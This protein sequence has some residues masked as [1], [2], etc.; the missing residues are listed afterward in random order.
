MA[1]RTTSTA[2]GSKSAA[3]GSPD[4]SVAGRSKRRE[5]RLSDTGSDGVPYYMTAVDRLTNFSYLVHTPSLPDFVVR[6]FETED[7]PSSKALLSKPAVNYALTRRFSRFDALEEEIENAVVALLGACGIGWAGPTTDDAGADVGGYAA[8]ELRFPEALA[9]FMGVSEEQSVADVLDHPALRRRMRDDPAVD[10]EVQKCVQNL[11]MRLR[12]F[13]ACDVT[14][15]VMNAARKI[16]DV[17]RF[18]Y[19]LRPDLAR[20]MDLL[21]DER[22]RHVMLASLGIVDPAPMRRL[23]A[24]W[25]KDGEVVR[26]RSPRSRNRW[27]LT[28]PPMTLGFFIENL[29]RFESLRGVGGV[30]IEHAEMNVRDAF[31]GPRWR[32]VRARSAAQPA[33]TISLGMREEVDDAFAALG[34]LLGE[35]SPE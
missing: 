29:N 18:R 7:N 10:R 32:P 13:R 19:T 27:D 5:P 4:S 3:K 35:P 9:T 23:A 21:V 2:K 25:E 16:D 14:V 20:T 12:W 1:C 34:A 28:Y 26:S 24:G 31:E 33:K 15:E 17:W 30:T 8:T 6:A 22:E 11:R